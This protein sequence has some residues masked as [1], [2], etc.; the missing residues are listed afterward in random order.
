MQTKQQQAERRE[1]GGEQTSTSTRQVRGGEAGP[2]QPNS[3]D[4]GK[5]EDGLIDAG[6]HDEQVKSGPIELVRGREH[7][8]QT[9][10]KL[11]EPTQAPACLVHLHREYKRIGQQEPRPDNKKRG[12]RD[13]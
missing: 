12:D 7:E 5:E 2:Q 9:A 1:L 10:I 13:S 4:D 6:R 11:C 8:N 3:H